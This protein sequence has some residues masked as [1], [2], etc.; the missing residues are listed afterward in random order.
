MI[1]LVIADELDLAG[2]GSQDRA[3]EADEDLR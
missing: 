2:D 3:A 1:G